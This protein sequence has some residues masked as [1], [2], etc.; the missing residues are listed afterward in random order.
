LKFL[1]E[2][3]EQQASSLQILSS[4]QAQLYTAEGALQRA[5]QQ[6]TYL[7]AMREQYEALTVPQATEN[8]SPATPKSPAL[9]QAEATLL[10]L[11]AQLVQTQTKFTDQHPT[12]SR[13]KEQIAAQQKA[14]KGLEAE[15]AANTPPETKK[16]ASA[17][18]ARLSM[19]EVE[20]RLKA[21]EGEIA[22]DQKAIADIQQQIKLVQSRLNMTP[23]REQQL[24]EITRS[25]ENSKEQYQSL[26]QKK[27]QSELASNLEK[28]QQ[29]EQFRILDPASLPE[30]A[31]GR[32]QILAGGW[33]VGL[34]IG[35]GLVV[36][37]EFVR[38]RLHD[39]EEIQL[40]IANLPLFQIPVIRTAAE[41]KRRRLRLVF[42]AAAA[43]CLALA[44][45]SSSVRAYFLS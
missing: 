13:L 27:L 41:A 12:V 10:D 21:I 43:T 42:E 29:G 15:Q 35:V 3:P 39:E 44:A 6:K 18:P 7:A 40:L 9:A 16:A 30:K 20:S 19:A 45:L 24:S 26:L 37:F 28:R 32:L 5:K 25:Y 33:G 14:V 22:G 11:Q 4:I 8:G 2:L 34:C 31:E 23:V 17:T 36:L 1:G 38:R